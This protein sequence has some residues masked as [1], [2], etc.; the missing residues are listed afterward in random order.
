MGAMERPMDPGLGSDRSNP[1]L[2]VSGLTDGC[3]LFNHPSLF[4]AENYQP[5]C[6]RD[7]AD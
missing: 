1:G 5:K 6:R 3:F 2:T 7:Q 4:P